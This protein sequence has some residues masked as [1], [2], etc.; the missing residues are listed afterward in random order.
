[1]NGTEEAQ[2]VNAA[3]W[4]MLKRRV[5][6]FYERN[7]KYRLFPCLPDEI[8]EYMFQKQCED[9]RFLMCSTRLCKRACDFALNHVPDED[10]SSCVTGFMV[11]LTSLYSRDVKVFTKASKHRATRFVEFLNR[12]SGPYWT[13]DVFIRPD[14]PQQ[15]FVA[16]DEYKI[17]RV[18][19]G[20]RLHFIRVRITRELMH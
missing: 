3:T 16:N 8:S 9:A 11:A 19:H 6:H 1:M 18:R 4:M 13:V 10:V 17:M 2:L 20:G 5:V 15:E 7:R 12:W 14:T